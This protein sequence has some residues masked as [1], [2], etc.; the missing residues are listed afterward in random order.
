MKI[1]RTAHPW[2]HFHWTNGFNKSSSA[3]SCIV[4]AGYEKPL[5][6][7]REYL[8]LSPAHRYRWHSMCYSKADHKDRAPRHLYLPSHRLPHH[9]VGFLVTTSSCSL[10]WGVVERLRT[11]STPDEWNCT[12]NYQ[13]SCS[14][15]K[16]CK[17]IPPTS[18]E[19]PNSA[20]AIK[21]PVRPFSVTA[22][23]ND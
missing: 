7:T 10:F 1:K 11:K 14:V 2:K 9:L 5:T 3:C 23:N 15:S 4:K 6:G 19:M 20:D 22:H 16:I 18:Q 21:I 17:N 8:L 13:N 12:C